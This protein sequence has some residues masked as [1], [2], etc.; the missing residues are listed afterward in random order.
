MANCGLAEGTGFRVEPGL[1][2]LHYGKLRSTAS[3]K[4]NLIVCLPQPIA[5]LETP[6][7]G[8]LAAWLVS[9]E[10]ELKCCSS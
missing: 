4:A 6:K 5:V 3:Y 7:K 10:R 8:T 2:V 9:V 1:G